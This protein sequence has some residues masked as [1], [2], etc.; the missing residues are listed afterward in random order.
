MQYI[1]YICKL[2]VVVNEEERDYPTRLGAWRPRCRTTSA[3]GLKSMPES[4][5]YLMYVHN[6]YS[7]SI[8]LHFRTNMEI[9]QT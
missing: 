7:V 2:L 6:S 5:P 1:S 8:F 3:R 4:M 9:G